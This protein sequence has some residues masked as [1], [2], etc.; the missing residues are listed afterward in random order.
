MKA[1]FICMILM[2]AMVSAEAQ[3]IVAAHAIR[4]RSIISAQDLAFLEQDT[5]G[6]I[7]SASDIIGMEARVNIY[8]GRP[9]RK[10]EVGA[11]RYWSEINW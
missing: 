7:T 9:I 10:S 3:T 11:R 6:G 5:V 1:L 8:A 4:A 2:G